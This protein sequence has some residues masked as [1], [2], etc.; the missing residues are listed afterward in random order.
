MVLSLIWTESGT[1][2]DRA[3]TLTIEIP[4]KISNPDLLHEDIKA[5]LISLMQIL[6]HVFC[7]KVDDAASLKILEGL[8]DLIHFSMNDKSL[9][10]QA[11][12]AFGSGKPMDKL[13][14]GNSIEKN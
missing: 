9:L 13:L 1:T 12:I 11:I 6:H 4:R 8:D 14:G 7:S 2:S 5:K 3:R 10:T